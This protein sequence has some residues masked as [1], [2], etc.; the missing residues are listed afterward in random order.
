L[1][2][3]LKGSGGTLG[4]V[5]LASAAGN[6]ESAIAAAG[7]ADADAI[8]RE[9]TAALEELRRRRSLEALAPV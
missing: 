5:R 8:R 2:H 3:E 9:A 4:F 6:F 7:T 1:V